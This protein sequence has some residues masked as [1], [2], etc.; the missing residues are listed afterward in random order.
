MTDSVR[1]KVYLAIAQALA[2][3]THANG[4]GT[5]PRVCE[6]YPEARDAQESQRLWVMLGSEIFAEDNVGGHQT[7]SLEL[8][9][10]GIVKRDHGDIQQ[11]A[12]AL[13]QDV[14]N[15]I[16]SQRRALAE[17]TGAVFTGFDRCETSYSLIDDVEQV[18]FD[19]PVV[20]TYI[21]GGGSSW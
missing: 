21:A 7:V 19:Q 17:S 13:I 12:N 11:Q 14:R 16:T 9:I 10:A 18:D 2:A 1:N 20:F 15:A 8:I 5:Q 4:Y 3:I 6:S